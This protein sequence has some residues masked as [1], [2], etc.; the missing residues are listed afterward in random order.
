M[1]I[2]KNIYKKTNAQKSLENRKVSYTVG[3]NV[4]GIAT[5]EN[6]MEFPQKTKN[7][8]TI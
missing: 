8:I 7:R 4:V 3:G 5:M 6:G 1:D 2:I